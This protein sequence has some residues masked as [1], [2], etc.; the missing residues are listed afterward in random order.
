MKLVIFDFIIEIAKIV[1]VIAY[2]GQDMTRIGH[3]QACKGQDI[4]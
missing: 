4:F 3:T 2:I 1:Q